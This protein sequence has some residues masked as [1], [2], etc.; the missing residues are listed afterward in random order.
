MRQGS[1]TTSAGV[2]GRSGD[3]TRSRRAARPVGVPRTDDQE[4]RQQ[5]PSPPAPAKMAGAG[6]FEP[7]YAGAKVPC[8]TAW[9]R[10]TNER[11]FR[12]GPPPEEHGGVKAAGPENSRVGKAARR[13]PGAREQRQPQ[14]G[15]GPAGSGPHGWLQGTASRRAA[16]RLCAGGPRG[17]PAPA[18]TPPSPFQSS[19]YG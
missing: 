2:A 11:G 17:A 15:W 1:N 14:V 18:R 13:L 9:P 19:T 5:G 8:L 4:T 16:P 12:H 6:G 7:P 3:D 10:P